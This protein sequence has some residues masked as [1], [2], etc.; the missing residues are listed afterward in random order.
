MFCAGGWVV[1]DFFSPNEVIYIGHTLCAARGGPTYK[2]GSKPNSS[3]KRETRGKG[4]PARSGQPQREGRRQGQ[5]KV[6][7]GEPPREGVLLGDALRGSVRARV[8][9]LSGERD[10]CSNRRNACQVFLLAA[11]RPEGSAQIS[12]KLPLQPE[13]DEQGAPKRHLSRRE[14][15]DD[16]LEQSRAT[17]PQRLWVR[18]SPQAPG[19]LCHTEAG[20]NSQ[21]VC[22]Q[23][24]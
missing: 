20:E 5:P 17:A 4:G 23:G 15:R 21:V 8:K 7:G 10:M 22:C 18:G 9:G 3:T 1:P 2:P 24:L 11:R 16:R 19:V 14:I 13:L 12:P 6:R